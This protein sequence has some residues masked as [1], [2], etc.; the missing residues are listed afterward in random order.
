MHARSARTR[1]GA[2]LALTA[3][4]MMGATAVSATAAPPDRTPPGLAKQDTLRWSAPK[5]FYIGTAVAGGGHH[6]EADYPEP[7]PNDPEYRAVLAREFNSLTPENQLK[8]DALR[9][10]QDEWNFGP[11]DAIVAFAAE[12]DQV[13]RGHTL[14]WHSQNPGWLEQGD[15]TANE[16]REILREHVYTVVGRYAG[17]IQQWDVANEIVDDRGNLRMQDN[18]W[19]RELGTDIIADVFRWAHEADP[20]ALLFFNDYNVEGINAKSNTYYALVQDLLAE[21]VPVHGFGAQ[22]HLGMQYGFDKGGLRANLQRFSDLGLQ[23]AITEIDVRDVLVEGRTTMTDAQLAK[24]ADWYQA[25][26][27]ACLAVEGCNSF[28]IWGVLDEHSWVQNFFAGQGAA[29]TMHG[30]YERKP[31]YYALQETLVKANPGGEARWERHPA[32]R[33]R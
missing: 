24:Q 12:N 22:G 21:G 4:A 30:D 17:Q 25:A 23:T 14:M 18:I 33:G 2:G 27:A 13:V 5:D 20:T 26:L 29:L 3:A 32:Y 6:L 28:T 31:A 9:P 15:F 16:L 7:F 11:A 1:L 10:S 19:L 8:W